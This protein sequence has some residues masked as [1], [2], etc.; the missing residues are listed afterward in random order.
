VPALETVKASASI[1]SGTPWHRLQPV[2]LSP[3]ADLGQGV[4]EKLTADTALRAEVL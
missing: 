4:G 3:G 1:E 2:S